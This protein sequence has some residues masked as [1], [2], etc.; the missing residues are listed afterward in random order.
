MWISQQSDVC[1]MFNSTSSGVKLF[2]WQF[3]KRLCLLSISRVQWTVC[4]DLFSLIKKKREGLAFNLTILQDYAMVEA[5]GL[6]VKQVPPPLGLCS[7][8][9]EWILQAPGWHPTQASGR[10]DA[11]LQLAITGFPPRETA[12]SVR[13]VTSEKLKGHLIRVAIDPKKLAFAS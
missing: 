10:T 8:E 12:A 4:I 11:T 6:E 5:T 1:F 3:S 13:L 7:P 2:R 9:S